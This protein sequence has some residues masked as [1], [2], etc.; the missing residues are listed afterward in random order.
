MKVKVISRSVDEFTRERSQDLQVI[1][2]HIIKIRICIFFVSPPQFL[3]I[4]LSI[5]VI[6]EGL[7]QLRPKSSTDGEGCG[8][9][10]SSYSCQIRKG[11]CYYLPSML[12]LCLIFKFHC[13]LVLISFGKFSQICLCFCF[14]SSVD[15]CKAVCRSNGRSSWWSLMYGEEPKLPQGNLLSFYGWR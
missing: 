5:S 7:S 6:P 14:S 9:P 13:A 4:F 2:L 15:I 11:F 12:F 8:I 10:E 3:S 1:F